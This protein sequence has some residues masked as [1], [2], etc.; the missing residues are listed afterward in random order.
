[1]GGLILFTFSVKEFIHPMSLPTESEHYS[2][3]N[4]AL[5]MGA[6]HTMTLL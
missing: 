2:F 4:K 1:M 3:E 5:H 6:K